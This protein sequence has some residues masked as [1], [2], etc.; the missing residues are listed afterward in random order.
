MKINLRALFFAIVGGLLLASSGSHAGGVLIGQPGAVLA[1][2]CQNG[3]TYP[4]HQRAVTEDGDLVTAYLVMVHGRGIHVRLIPMGFGYRYAGPGIWFDGI[5][6][7]A[8]LYLTKYNPVPCHVV[9]A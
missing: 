9:A 8:L 7:E 2:S 3:H 1:L 4:I 5:R 6:G